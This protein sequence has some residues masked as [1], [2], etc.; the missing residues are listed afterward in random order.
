MHHHTT[1][2]IRLRLA[3]SVPP[4]GAPITAH[5]MNLNRSAILLAIAIIVALGC[6]PIGAAA[7]VQ[8]LPGHVPK[9]AQHLRAIGRMAPQDR[10]NLAISLPLRH[11]NELAQLLRDLYDPASPRFHHYLT[12]SQFAEQ[13]GPTPADYQAVLAFATANGFE[14]IGTHPNRTLLDVRAS[15][16]NIE[17]TLHLHLNKYA[18]PVEKRTFFSPDADP[19]L[20]LTVPVLYI[21]GLSDL[22]QPRPMNTG[23]K[24]DHSSPLG[25]PL[26]TGSATNGG[27]IGQDFRTAY[28]P[29]VTLTGAGQSVG[30]FELSGGYY[31]S[32]IAEYEAQAAMPNVPITPVLL[33]GYDGSPGGW[34]VNAEVSLDIEMAIAMAP[35]LDQV[36]VYEGMLP[37]SILNRMATD[38]IAKQLSAS[39]V[40]G[41]D[42][43]SQQIFQEFA[44]QGQSF[45]NS[46][47]DG[48]A[49]G[50]SGGMPSPL[51]DPYI[52]IVGGTLL[53]TTTA[54]GAWASETVWTGSGGGISTNYSIPTW[55]QGIDMSA[56]SGSTTNRNTPDVALTADNVYIV[57]VKGSTGTSGGTSASTP[58]WAGYTALINQLAMEGGQQPVGFLNPAIYT[59]GKGAYETYRTKFHD[60]TTGNTTNTAN[61]GGFYAVQGYDLCTGWGTPAGLG[62]INTL[63][64]PDILLILPPTGFDSAGGVGGP[65]TVSALALTLTNTGSSTIS[66][67]S[68]SPASWLNLSAAS[69]TVGPGQSIN[70]TASLTAAAYSLP[71]GAYT[72]TI[73]FTNQYDSVVFPRTFTLA[74]LAPAGIGTQPTNQT[75]VAQQTAAFNVSAIG[76]Q[77]LT[78]QWFF[79]GAPLTDRG[80][81]FGSATSSLTI[82]NTSVTN[83]GSYY[84]VVTNAARQVTSSNVILTVIPQVAIYQQPLSELVSSASTAVFTVAAYGQLPLTYQWKLNGTDISSATG[85]S[86]IITN[87]Q[88][89]QSGTYTVTVSNAYDGVVS[90][91]ALLATVS[92][93]QV[94]INFD[95]L[96]A[97]YFAVTNGYGGLNW[98]NF[99]SGPGSL[100]PGS[101]WSAGVI[102][103]PNVAGNGGGGTGTISRSSP[104]DL[105]SCY[106]TAV[107]SSVQQV[108][109]KGYNDGVLL[110]DLTNNLS[111]TTP[112][113]FQFGYLGVTEVDFISLLS[114]SPGGYLAM[115]NMVVMEGT[116]GSGSTPT[117]SLQVFLQP[118]TAISSGAR[119]QVDGGL[120]QSS[121]A[122]VSGLTATYHT[123]NFLPANGWTMPANQTVILVAHQSATTTGMYVLPNPPFFQA[124]SP[125]W[126]ANGFHVSV[127]NGSGFAAIVQSST[128]LRTWNNI[129]TNTGSFLFTD[130]DAL[131]FNP[132]YY[133]L[134]IP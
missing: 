30:L 110:Y 70:V 2:I 66:W 105:I 116:N 65:Y 68:S 71:V 19:S 92:A 73:F 29:N 53:T 123:V 104:F 117:G 69:G 75:V 131:H 31:P 22:T 51:D 76:G 47:G 86:L 129:S 26:A 63:A 5:R 8:T 7:A 106:V 113:N 24:P 57:A 34:Q 14:I 130:P 4:A 101:G 36:L 16:A 107:F 62:L 18:H 13:F 126:D 102:S 28:A 79:N 1:T 128:N 44:T 125:G 108:E 103:P 38:N 78:Y 39:W 67:N 109:A 23:F 118:A 21:A 100:T 84:V 12:A 124:G 133:R 89:P 32:D 45:F 132:Q 96:P 43:E 72:N 11:T 48:G 112:T 114:G 52:T 10:L 35:G 83:T 82:T 127:S 46:S 98:T 17:N 85:S 97:Y 81:I 88:S 27:F 9:A 121:G 33:N 50:V 64:H 119:W 54:G 15:V 61:P 74:V 6:F 80:E 59:I 120:P 56:S 77:P 93:S 60:I 95:V 91:P 115:D 41:I 99:Y 111:D 87:V 58:L 37:D 49:W 134:V 55:Q 94:T 25:S 90:A 122:I 20:D 3:G 40:Y 42:S